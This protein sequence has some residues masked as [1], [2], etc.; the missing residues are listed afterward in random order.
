MTMTNTADVKISGNPDVWVLLC[1]VSSEEEFWMKS[2]K[3][4]N[5][6]TGAVLQ[7]TTQHGNT[8]IHKNPNVAEALTFIPG[9]NF[10]KTGDGTFVSSLITP[11]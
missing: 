2:T 7:V 5:T 6:P 11:K 3:F 1:E 10:Y 8:N 4:M 9:I